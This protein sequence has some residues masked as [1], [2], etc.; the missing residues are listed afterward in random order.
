MRMNQDFFARDVLAVAPDLIG[1][2]ICRRLPDGQVLRGMITE[3][4]AYRGQEDQ[5]CHAR[6]GRTKR[7][8]V[9]FGPPGYAYIYLIYGLH[10]LFNIVTG[11][12][13]EPQAV[14]I[15]ALERPLDGPAKWTKAF[16]VTGSQNGLYLPDSREVWMEDGEK[17]EII[18]APR[19][20][21]DYADE[22]WKSIPWRFIA[23]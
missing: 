16:L 22:P 9:M 15:R 21:I 17:K 3:T 6:M 20:G 11:K 8:E 2:M 12:E 1:K 10:W 5:A 19:V 18:T 4:E 23:K 13:N 7:N 14:L